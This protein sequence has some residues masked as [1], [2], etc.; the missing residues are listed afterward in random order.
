MKISGFEIRCQGQRIS[1]GQKPWYSACHWSIATDKRWGS[2]WDAQ[3]GLLTLV[4]RFYR[5]SFSRIARY[6]Q[7]QNLTDELQ[8]ILNGA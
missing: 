2:I 3:M 6:A 7:G 4:S 5:N 1:S 8:P